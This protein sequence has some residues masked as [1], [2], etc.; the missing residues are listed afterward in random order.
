MN[1]CKIW[2]IESK[3]RLECLDDIEEYI[4]D[5]CES[6]DMRREL[7]DIIVKYDQMITNAIEKRGEKHDQTM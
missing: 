1:Q 2:R 3:L 5:H 6:R 4:D 7:L